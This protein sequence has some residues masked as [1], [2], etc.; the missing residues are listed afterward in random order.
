MPYKIGQLDFLF[1][2]SVTI[3]VED[4]LNHLPKKKKKHKKFMIA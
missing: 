2:L 1:G 4:R 3:A